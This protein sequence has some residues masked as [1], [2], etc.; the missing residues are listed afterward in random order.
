MSQAKVATKTKVDV[1]QAAQAAMQYFQRLFPAVT[2]FSLEEVELSE[3]EKYWMIT[4]GYDVARV[5]G[6][7]ILRPP[8]TKYKV[9]KVNATTGEVLAMKI[10]SLQ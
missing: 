9:F 4:L 8:T 10:R 3:D 5:S 1:R 7:I 6:S 2:H